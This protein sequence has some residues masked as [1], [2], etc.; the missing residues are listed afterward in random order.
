MKQFYVIKVE[1]KDI[2]SVEKVLFTCLV[3]RMNLCSLVKL[4]ELKIDTT[5]S[6]FVL[7]GEKFSCNR[8]LSIAKK[9]LTSRDIIIKIYDYNSVRNPDFDDLVWYSNENRIG[10]A[11]KTYYNNPIMYNYLRRLTTKFAL[12]KGLFSNHVFCTECDGFADAVELNSLKGI[13][14]CSFCDAEIIVEGPLLTGKKP[15][16][17][18]S[19]EEQLYLIGLPSMTSIELLIPD[20]TFNGEQISMAC[21]GIECIEPLSKTRRRR[22]KVFA[23]TNSSGVPLGNC[24]QIFWNIII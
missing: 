3:D 12:K 13:Y 22:R 4:V 1:K 7:G 17:H 6:Y 18:L 11:I 21:D 23:I 2:R 14:K 5:H 15:I 9:I 19:T 8:V 20:E 16:T 24:E 10:Q